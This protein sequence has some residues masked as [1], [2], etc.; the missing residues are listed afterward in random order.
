MVRNTIL[1]RKSHLYIFISQIQLW[2]YLLIK[3]YSFKDVEAM[4]D[5]EWGQNVRLS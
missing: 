5:S 2:E 4:S 1:V 3:I